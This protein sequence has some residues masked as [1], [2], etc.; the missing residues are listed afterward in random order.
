[1]KI[2][3]FMLVAG[4]A[5]AFAAPLASAREVITEHSYLPHKVIKH[6]SPTKGQT[7]PRPPLYIFVPGFS[8]TPSSSPDSIDD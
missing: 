8:G 6:V 7:G 5:F 3:T 4:A 1:M 2:S